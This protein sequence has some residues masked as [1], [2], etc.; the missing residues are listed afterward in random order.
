VP[1][2]DEEEVAG[3]DRVEVDPGER[4]IPLEHVYNIWENGRH[5]LV[6]YGFY[7]ILI[8]EEDVCL[9]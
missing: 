3:A 4:M 2:G 6:L 7:T 9:T 1:E 5:K 8:H